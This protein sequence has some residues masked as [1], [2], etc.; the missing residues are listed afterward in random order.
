MSQIKKDNVLQI[1]CY[2]QQVTFVSVFSGLK[3]YR[4]KVQTP[5][6][7]LGLRLFKIYY[8]YCFDVQCVSLRRDRYV[9]VTS[10]ITKIKLTLFFS[11]SRSYSLVSFSWRWRVISSSI[12]F[13]RSFSRWISVVTLL[14]IDLQRTKQPYY[15]TIYTNINSNGSI[16]KDIQL[17]ALSF[18]AP[19]TLLVT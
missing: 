3:I 13:C 2:K 11:R 9:L 4:C 16:S 19:T 8:I 1:P 7:I 6:V 17:Q 14:F 10:M 12:S 18:V 15:F 5:S